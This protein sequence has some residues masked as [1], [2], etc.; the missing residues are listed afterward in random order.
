M[1]GIKPI[2]AA[3]FVSC[4]LASC[5]TE[6]PAPQVAPQEEEGVTSPLPT[7]GFEWLVIESNDGG[8]H[9]RA[10]TEPESIPQ[11]DPFTVHVQVC[12]DSDFTMPVEDASVHVDAAMPD[13]GHGMNVVPEMVQVAP[14][15]W[16]ARGL[17][18]HM[19]GKWEVYV[20][21]VE[22]GLMERTQWLLQL[23]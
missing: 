2:H 7:D 6:A 16:E 13:H 10:R 22:D 23:D 4:L 3:L 1:A 17:L 18:M 15:C 20:D 14:G 19:P 12:H 5:G 8:Y 11:R 21:V 9:V